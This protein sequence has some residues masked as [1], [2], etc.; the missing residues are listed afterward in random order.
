VSGPE[1]RERSFPDLSTSFQLVP[2][3]DE[4]GRSSMGERLD[5]FNARLPNTAP[6]MRTAAAVI[7]SDRHNS[8]DE[9][10]LRFIGVPR[11]TALAAAAYFRASLRGERISSQ[12]EAVTDPGIQFSLW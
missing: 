6:S 9:F 10:C 1:V 12:A 5:T 4:I 11:S 3:P 7:P 8:T 2:G